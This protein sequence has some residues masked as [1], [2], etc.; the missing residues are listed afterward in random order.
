M[1]VT[2]VLHQGLGLAF[3]CING[4]G[5]VCVCLFQSDYSSC[6]SHRWLVFYTADVWFKLNYKA[7]QVFQNNL[8]QN[9]LHRK[10]LLQNSSKM[11]LF[12]GMR[13]KYYMPML[14]SM[15]FDLD[16]TIGWDFKTEGGGI[17][18]FVISTLTCHCVNCIF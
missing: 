13:Y 16:W 4:F 2:P 7:A 12:F 9:S 14:Q 10:H 8:S 6:K 18:T 3:F 15:Q 5:F 1:T 17:I 11:G